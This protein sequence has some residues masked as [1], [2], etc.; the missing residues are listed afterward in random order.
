MDYNTQRERL[1]MPEYGRMVQEMVDYALT[2]DDRDARQNCAETII[3]VMENFFPNAK[4]MPDFEYKL[5][6]HLAAIS[7]YKLDVDYP[8]GVR[9]TPSN[10]EAPQ[11]MPYPMQ[12]I[13]QRTYGHMIEALLGKLKEMPASE[14]RHDLALIVAQQMVRTLQMWNKDALNVNKIVD[15]IERYTDGRVALRPEEVVVRPMA[16]TAAQRTM[17]RRRKK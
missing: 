1:V 8:G 6:D 5:W 14:E 12:R 17:G 3:K 10:D 13:K 16:A 15:D 9:P 4:S 2:I 7:H 11:P